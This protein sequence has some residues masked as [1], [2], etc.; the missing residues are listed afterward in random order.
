MHN[1]ETQTTTLNFITKDYR[2]LYVLYAVIKHVTYCSSVKQ[3]TVFYYNY[4]WAY[5]RRMQLFTVRRYA[6]TVYAVV[7]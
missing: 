4:I 5:L 3:S 1:R 2:F 6:S 7:M